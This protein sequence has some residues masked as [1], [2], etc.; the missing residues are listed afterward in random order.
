MR[1]LRYP[2]AQRTGSI[3]GPQ[4]NQSQEVR[5]HSDPISPHSLSGAT[6][7]VSLLLS[8]IFDLP[9]LL[10]DVLSLL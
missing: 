4:R 9:P 10:L 1:N 7:L 6:G 8:G 2:I 5:R 3:A